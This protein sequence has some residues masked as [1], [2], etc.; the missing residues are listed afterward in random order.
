MTLGN[1]SIA[2]RAVIS[3]GVIALLVLLQGLFALKQVAEVRATGQHTENISLPSTRYLGEV[4]DYVLSIRVLSLR[5]ALNREPK[6]LESTIARLHQVQAWLDQALARFAPLVGDHNRV[7]YETFLA[8]VKSY[9]Q[10]LAQYEALS[11]DNR[12]SE[13]TALLNG[14]IQDYSTQTGDQFAELMNLTAEEVS[15]S[16]QHA[17]ALYTQVKITVIGALIAVALL[18]LC[19]AWLL[20]RSIVVPIRQ[21]VGVAEQVAAGDLSRPIHS[22]GRDE[23]ARLLKALASMQASLRETLQLISSTS[24]QLAAAAQQMSQ[25][26]HQD[27]SRLQQQHNE[28]EQAA[29]AVNE[30]TVAVEE[31]ARNAVSTSD[32]TR[33]STTQATQGQARVIQT[34]DSIQAMSSDVGTALQQVQTLAEQ[35]REIG[36]VLDVIRAIAEQTNLLALNAAIEAARAGEAGRGFAVVADEVRALAHRTQQ[37][38]QEIEQMIG[39]VQGDTDS[40]VQSMHGNN[41]RVA[42]TLSIAEQAGL[43]LGEITRAM[44]QIHERNLVIASASEEQAQVAREVDRNLLNIRDLSLES[45]DAATRT[46]ATSQELSHLAAGLQNLVVRFRF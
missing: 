14:K 34:L 10:A 20:I 9:Q 26:T 28:I 46:N 37:S 8:T 24:T 11:Q 13:M 40:V 39:R 30:M 3:F 17:D 41:Q 22:E 33:Q 31:V 12:S 6:V 5:M 7:Q 32:T 1:L 36:K 19:L 43:A 21:A 27:S 44:E 16:A 15:Q 35:S 25:S 23:T 2:K 29:T 42:Q 45:A 4:R 18:T 38:T